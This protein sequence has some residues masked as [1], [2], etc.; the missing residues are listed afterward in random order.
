M[1]RMLK[2]E[3]LKLSTTRTFA[4]LVGSALALTLLVVVLTATLANDQT[5]ED[6]EFLFA[7][8][9][10]SLFIFLLGIMGMAGEWRHRTI[11]GSVLAAPQ[12]VKFL[13]AKLL[14]YATAGALL[15]LVVQLVSMGI[16]SALL[17]QQDQPTLA[18][19]EL[20]DIVW[21]NLIVSA[22]AGAFGV[23]VGALLRNQVVAI[24]GL[25]IFSFAAEPAIL[26]YAEDVGRFLPTTGVP[27][28]VVDAGDFG[29]DVDLL[30]LG[31]GLAAMVAWVA[32]LF[33]AGAALLKRRD[34]I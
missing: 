17:S 16:G 12:R 21:R 25:L 34:L 8:D 26:F 7:G 9:F 3:L 10:S 2:A 22:Y 14:A 27:S 6:V 18:I 19:S 23:C 11:T 20:A 24:V 15:S 30:S 5:K 13:A 32:V 28:A 33:A 29:D 4:A 1:S 31:A